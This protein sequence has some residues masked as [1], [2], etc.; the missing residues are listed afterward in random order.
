MVSESIQDQARAAIAAAGQ[1]GRAMWGYARRS[2][3]T[4]WA[5]NPPAAHQLFIIPQDLRTADPSFASELYDGYFGLAGAVAATG[6]ESPFAVLP[7]SPA[8]QREL[9]TFSWLRNLHAAGDE[10]SQD[11]ARMLMANW[12]AAGRSAPRIASDADV[13]AQRVIALLSHAGFILDGVDADFY[14]AFMRMLTGELRDLS[15][16]RALRD[17]GAA[18]LRA[19]VAL[20]FAGLCVAEQQSYLSGYVSGLQAELDRQ[21]LPDGG[22]ISRN[23]AVL[24]DLLLDLMPLKHCFTARKLDPPEFLTSAIGRII[25]MLRFFRHGGGSLARFHGA[26]TTQMDLLAAALVYDETG[27]VAGPYAPDSGYCRLERGQTVIIADMGAP[28]PMSESARAHAS[29]LAF[30]LSDGIDPIIVNCGAPA[31]EYGDWAVVCRST[32]AHS[33]LTIADQS[34]SRLVRRSSLGGEVYQLAGP[35]IINPEFLSDSGEIEFRATHDGFQEQF[36]LNHRRELR[37]SPDG[38]VV[39]G[40]DLLTDPAG[41]K[42]IASERP[43]FAVRFH[44]H[45]NVEAA[46]T[47]DPKIMVLTLPNEESWY[48]RAHNALVDIDESIYLADPVAPRRSLQVVLSGPCIEDAVIAWSL[49]KAEGRKVSRLKPADANATLITPTFADEI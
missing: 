16:N 5:A 20:T 12:I 4:R 30:E 11:K 45:P 2:P 6:S 3:V 36:G 10:V 24:A 39:E 48:L 23:P 32:A 26:G 9:Y 42:M 29:A 28:P 49:R 14:D 25:P 46:R 19:V 35:R 22:H 17:H 41:K 15:L 43:D 37:L 31:D 34:S 27:A 38:K 13:A 44:L 47:G 18:S 40:F 1:A 8:W 7:P 21:I 33:T